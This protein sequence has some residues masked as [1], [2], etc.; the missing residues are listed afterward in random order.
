MLCPE[1]IL[2]PI[3]FEPQENFEPQK[4]SVVNKFG[5]KKNWNKTNY[6]PKIDKDPQKILCPK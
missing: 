3:N 6:G 2:C 5:A 4:I 1:I